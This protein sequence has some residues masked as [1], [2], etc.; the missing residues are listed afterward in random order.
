MK[1]RRDKILDVAVELAEKG[2]FENVRQREVAAL[3]GVA[4]GTLYK[5][6]RSKEDILSAALDRQAEQL[7]RKMERKP[8]AGDTEAERVTALFQM[9]TRQL[10]RKPQYA[11][12]VVRAMASGEAEVAQ[13]VTAYHSRIAGLVIAALRGQ[14]RLSYTDA[15]SKPPSEQEM[16]LA[17]L[18]LQVWFASLV[19][20]SAGLFG[21]GKIIEQTQTAA[22]LLIKGLAAEAA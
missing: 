15:T 1:D 13:N 17:F 21:Q 12:A 14:G 11:R 22:E 10:C 16:T 19:G 5:S 20:W 7:E 4:L 3:A 18:L 9:L 6:F 2:G 8:A